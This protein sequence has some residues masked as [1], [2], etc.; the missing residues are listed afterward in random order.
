MVLHSVEI[1]MILHFLNLKLRNKAVRIIIDVPL[2]EPITPPYTS[3]GHLYFFTTILM[4]KTFQLKY[5]LVSELNGYDTRSVSYNLL[6][7]PS[8]QTN[9]RKSSPTIL[10]MYKW[11]DIPQ[12]V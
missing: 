8:L 3:L 4:L 1:F 6:L 11:N 9:L 7:I 5:P 10:G 2:M 12:P